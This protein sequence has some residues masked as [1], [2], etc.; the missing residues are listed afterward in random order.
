MSVHF[1]QGQ[2]TACGIDRRSAGAIITTIHKLAVTCPGCQ[3]TSVFKASR[4]TLPKVQG[5][6]YAAK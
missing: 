3:E 1:C 4:Q 2:I 6:P 5:G